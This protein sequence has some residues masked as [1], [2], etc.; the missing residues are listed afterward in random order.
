MR[1]TRPLRNQYSNT[2]L[3]KSWL[4]ATKEINWA[5]HLTVCLDEMVRT[6]VSKEVTFELS[7]EGQRMG[8]HGKEEDKLWEQRTHRQSPRRK[9]D[10]RAGGGKG[11]S[12]GMDMKNIG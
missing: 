8:T 2:K 5:L 11:G 12:W 7:P 3:T 9:W 10:C 1:V 6:G 4:N